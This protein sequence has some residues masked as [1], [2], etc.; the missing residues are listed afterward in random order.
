MKKDHCYIACDLGAD[1]GRVMLGKLE[2]C[3]LTLEEVYRFSNGP[4]KINGSLRWDILRI[5]EE[6]KIGLRK[7]ADKNIPADSLSVDSWGIDYVLLNARQPMLSLPYQYRDA[8]TEAP[9]ATALE[10]YGSERIFSETGIQFMPINTLYQLMDDVKHNSDLLAVA[11]QFLL[12]GDYLNFLFSGV[13]RAEESL[14]S[15]TQIYNP[16]SRAWSQQLIRDF[17]FPAALFPEIVKSG[18]VLGPMTP[19]IEEETGLSGIQVVAACSH[20]T[21]AA[22][23][24]VPAEGDDWA[25]LSSGTW[26]LIGVELQAPLINEAVREQNF[27]NEAGYAGTTR[28]LKNIIGLWILQEC[29]RDWARDG[30]H[31]DYSEIDRL[32]DEALPFRSLINPN[33]PRFL[34]PGSMPEK[35]ASYCEETGQAVPES[36]GQFARCIYESLALRYRTTLDQIEELIGR[37][38]SRLHI[39]GGGSK[40]SLLN[41]FAANATGR[42]VLAGPVEATAC[43]NVLIQALALGH[44]PNLAALRDVVRTSFSIRTY[45][46]EQ[47]DEWREASIRFA[48]LKT[49]N[50]LLQTPACPSPNK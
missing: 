8:R 24:A 50:P 11:D 30:H 38:I 19:A 2:S 13:A 34:S 37:N 17:Q 21:G 22:V 6:L 42:T 16:K 47:S 1:S 46:P 43:G 27:T 49:L 41:Q 12:V 23:A 20:D 5:F 35:I 26:S 40:G 25:Y 32:A 7:F 28:F 14:A 36:P 4:A 9:Y 15:T 33:A 44:L 31:L 29:K 45:Q 3:W 10:T 48:S 39:V 18:T